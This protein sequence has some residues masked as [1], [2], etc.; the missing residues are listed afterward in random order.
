MEKVFVFYNYI[1]KKTVMII[2]FL[3][4]NN[5]TMENTYKI[6]NCKITKVDTNIQN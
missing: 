6:F 5:D 3:L 1:I 4:L 2:K